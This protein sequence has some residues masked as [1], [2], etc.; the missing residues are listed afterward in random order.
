MRRT[1]VTHLCSHT[2][3][4]LLPLV[5]AHSTPRKEDGGAK[6]QKDKRNR[7]HVA[8]KLP[9]LTYFFNILQCTILNT[10]KYMCINIFTARETSNQLL[11]V[12]YFNNKSIFSPLINNF[13]NIRE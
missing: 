2:L 8:D 6:K 10:S 5:L 12:S 11:N 13:K 4:T 7:L 3:F 1:Y 9:S